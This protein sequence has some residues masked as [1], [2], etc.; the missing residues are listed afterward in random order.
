MVTIKFFS[1]KCYE[2]GNFSF[3]NQMLMSTYNLNRKFPDI[4]GNTE[5]AI[6]ILVSK[7]IVL[8]LNLGKSHRTSLLTRYNLPIKCWTWI[9]MCPVH[10]IFNELNYHIIKG[11]RKKIHL[12]KTKS[13]IT[14][15]FCLLRYFKGQITA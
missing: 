9:M 14:F 15:T 7:Y 8:F 12:K 5:T 11:K 3:W 13:I 10:T 4:R 2:K 6:C 1:Q